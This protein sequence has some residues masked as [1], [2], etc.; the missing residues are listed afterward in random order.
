LQRDKRFLYGVRELTLTYN[1]TGAGQTGTRHFNYY[2]V[3]AIRYWNPELRVNVVKLEPPKKKK[4]AK[5]DADADA[6]A[7][8][9]PAEAAV[10]T[11]APVKVAQKEST[12]VLRLDD[13][14]DVTV[15]TTGLTAAQIGE[16]LKP[17][18]TN[19]NPIQRLFPTQ[20][21]QSA[22]TQPQQQQQQQQQQ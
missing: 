13:G 5:S 14:S 12:L 19:P 8:D 21:Q 6:P 7:A 11:A 1:K 16:K 22:R 4:I 3:P 17:F 15:P 20:T 2:A 9:A 10:E 18:M